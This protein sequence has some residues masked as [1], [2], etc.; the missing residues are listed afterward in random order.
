MSA[1]VVEQPHEQPTL[2][3]AADIISSQ[4]VGHRVEIIGS[5]ITVTPPANGPHSESLTDVMV[6]LLAAGLHGKTSRVLQAIGLWLPTGPS[7]YA[8]PDLV[9][10]DGDYKD[11][12]VEFNCYAPSAFR[13]VLE[14]TSSNHSDDVKRKPAVYAS[15][16]VPVY[17]I[18]DR[19]NRKIMVLTEPSDGEYR[20]H[21]IHHPGQSFTLPES[22]G[23]SVALDVDTVLG[24][25][26]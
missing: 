23:A 8:I 25:E 21:A 17:V 1:A 5:Q 10:V 7:D 9:L 14:V 16:G 6:A 12:H 20:V 15:A 13:L 18:V 3:E 26:K 22:I 24:S 19:R 11:H 4:L 2:L